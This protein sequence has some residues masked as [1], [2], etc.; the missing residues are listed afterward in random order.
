[1][2]A[3]PRT[4]AGRIAPPS[5]PTVVFAIEQ[6]RAKLARKQI[7]ETLKQKL[8]LTPFWRDYC[9][10]AEA[11]PAR[12]RMHGLVRAL[13][14]LIVESAKGSDG[15][16]EDAGAR[17]CLTHLLEVLKQVMK[18]RGAAGQEL[19]TP[20]Q[21]LAHVTDCQHA[22]YRRLQNEAIEIAA[23]LKLLAKPHKPKKSGAAP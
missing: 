15:Q 17:A 4:A 14:G 20:E 23:W 5:Q 8:T 10:E 21:W 16:Q 9:R 6:M 3:P 11:L 1:M 7:S 18:Q 2:A 13:A 22:E 12:I 19:A